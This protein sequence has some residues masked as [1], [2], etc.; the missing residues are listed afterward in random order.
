VI[1][2]LPHRRFGWTAF[3]LAGLLAFLWL[4]A[5]SR[6]EERVVVV[7]PHNEAIRFEFSRAFESWHAAQFGEA[8]TVEWRVVG[9]TSDALR[10]V[11]SEFA[12]KPDGIG[13]DCFFGGG[14]EPLLL[15]ADQR[16]TQPYRPAPEILSAIP[17]TCAGVPIYD[18]D[19]YWYGAAISSFGIVQNTRVQ[20]TLGLPPVRRW[21]DLARPELFGWVE[22]GD[23][24]NSGTMTVMF[25]SYLQAYGWERGWELL[26]RLGANVRQF[27][28][29][30]AATAREVTLGEAAYG[31]AIDFYG[32]SQ[33]AVAG[34]TNMTFVLPQDFAAILPDGI[35]LL[36]GAPHPRTARRFIDFVLGE[37]GQKL[38]FLPRGHPEGPQRHSIERMSVRP[39]F[40]RRYGEVSNIAFSPFELTQHF[41]YDASLARARRDV[42]AALVGALLVDT[43]AELKAAWRALLRRGLPP[44]ETA[45]LSRPPLGDAETLTLATGAW[46]DPA[47]R[48][49][50][51]I[52]WQIFAREKYRRIARTHPAHAR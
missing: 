24:R 20:A 51:K 29:V 10:F 44:A 22:A 17:P 34:R 21:A 41:R 31:L 25:E 27:D 14:P 50:L 28:R 6:A 13:L 43:H 3:W 8:A 18:P 42:I 15:L 1:V 52:D 26:V 4:A 16:L 45:E 49:R 11:Q 19:G 2:V 9:G 35:A 47:T 46:K 38:W 30:S 36:K 33:V 40:Y 23:P 39:D 12:A 5:L 37:P 7:S 32:Y 48:N